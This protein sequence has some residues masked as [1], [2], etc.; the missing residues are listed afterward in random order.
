MSTVTLLQG[1]C[2]E[3]FPG[4]G[5]VDAVITDPP[6][7]TE[8]ARVPIRG[9]GVGRF[10]KE[11]NS[12]GDEWGYSLDWVDVVGTLKPKHWVVFANFAMLGELYAAIGKYAKVSCLFVWYKNNAP[13]MTSPVP[14]FDCEFI[15][16]ARA[17][18]VQCCTM[19]DFKSM[20]LDVNNLQAGCFAKE[21]ILQ[22]DS[23]KAAHPC[24]KP[25]AVVIPF[26]ERLGV[27]T[28]LD[29]FMGSGTTGVA[30]VKLG[31]SFIGIEK[32]PQY[33]EIARKRIEQAQQQIML[34]L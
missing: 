3:L 1:D 16:W 26:V 19:R 21:R 25:L 9:N 12:V 34:P 15:L 27:D 5:D 23:L 13:A 2:L 14:R 32:D 10:I 31:R 17:D 22:T 28:I 7:L 30:C 33:F 29:P 8:N 4:L 18:G 6:Y 20:I 11:T 24:Q